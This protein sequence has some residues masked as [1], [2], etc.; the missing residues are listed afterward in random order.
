MTRFFVSLCSRHPF[1]CAIFDGNNAFGCHCSSHARAGQGF[2]PA[3]DGANDV[4]KLVSS[5]I[6]ALIV[7]CGVS[8]AP[9]RIGLLPGRN[10]NARG[11]SVKHFVL[12]T[13]HCVL[14]CPFL[15]E[16]AIRWLWS[17]AFVFPSLGGLVC[18]GLCYIKLGCTASLR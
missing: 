13:V 4:S 15:G 17:L 2:G 16:R 18:W 9:P 3:R 12:F 14:F 7:F 10:G 6:A 5:C 8:R 1:H 11:R